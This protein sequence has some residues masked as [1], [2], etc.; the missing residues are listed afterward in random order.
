VFTIIEQNPCIFVERFVAAIKH[1]YVVENSNKG[2][3]VDGALKEINLFKSKDEY[4]CAKILEYGET[5]ISDYDAQVFLEK[6]Q[7]AVIQKAVVDYESLHW[8]L[9]S[10]K[11][12]KVILSPPHSKEELDGM[13][14]DTLKEVCRKQ[15]ITGR[16]R[17]VLI[18]KYLKAT[19]VV[20]ES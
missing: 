16:D 9:T 13:D 7:W 4:G 8:G 3:V 12:V 1:G 2:W 19:G 17:A 5:I 15:G 14:W 18:N 6:L 11:S 10:L 20:Y